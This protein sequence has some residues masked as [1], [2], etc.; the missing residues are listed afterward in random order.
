MVLDGLV[1]ADRNAWQQ[2]A[3]L[4]VW[5]TYAVT[6][7]LVPGRPRESRLEIDL[8]LW[9]G[10]LQPTVIKEE[11][12]SPFAGEA[13]PDRVEAALNRLVHQVMVSAH[14]NMTQS[15]TASNRM[16]IGQSLVETYNQMT[17]PTGHHREELGFEDPGKFLQAAH[18][19]ETA[20][21]FDPDNANA[22][23]LYISYRWGFWINFKENVKNQFW[24]KW[25]CSQAWGKY[26]NRFGLK[27]V[28]VDLPFPYQ[29]RGGLPEAY[30]NSLEEALKMFPQWDSTNEMENKWQQEG[31]HTWLVEAELH[32]FPK[33][34]PRDLA[35]KWQ[36]ETEAELGRRKQKVAEYLQSISAITNNH[37]GTTTSVIHQATV[38]LAPRPVSKPQNYSQMVPT[39]S[40]V[41]GIQTFQAFDSMFR[42]FPPNVLPLEVQPNM[43]E[44]RFPKQFEVQTIDHLDFLD[45]KLLILAMDERSVPSSDNNPDV[46]AEMLDKHNRLW[47]LKP[48]EGSPTLYEPDLFPQS[49]N[50]FLLKDGQLWVAGKTTGFLDLKTHDFR[51]FGLPD[52][53]DLQTSDALGFAGGHIF[54]A[55]DWF[56]VSMFDAAQ[57]HWSNLSLPPANLS[58]GTGSPFLLAGNKQQLVCVAGS[59]LIHDFTH[60]SWTNLAYPNS[61][62][63]ILADDS[64]FWFGGRDGLHSYDPASKSFKHWSAPSTINSLFTSTMGHSFMGNDEIPARD[65]ERMDEQ[66]QGLMNKLQ[67]DRAKNH[68]AKHGKN[69]M[70]DPLHL[71]WRVPGEATALANDGDF[72]WV[73][74]GNYFGNYLLLLHKPSH[75]LVAFCPMMARDHISSLTVSSTSIWIGTAYGDHKLLQLP[76]SP[77]LSVPQGRWVSLTIS[78]EERAQLVRNMDVRDQAMYAFYADDDARVA[79]LL[80]GIDPDKASLEEMFILAFSYDASGLDKPELARD[81]FEHIISRYP[82]S[83]WAKFARSA[84]AQ[85]EQ[86]HKDKMHEEE[87]LAKYD[88]DHNGVL[89]PEE[90]RVMERDPGYQNERKIWNADRL[91]NQLEK[92]M[93]RFDRNKDGKLDRGELESLK[94]QVTVFSQAPPEKLVGHKNPVV[95]LMTKKFPAVTDILQKYDVNGDGGLEAGELKMLAQ[96][97]QKGQ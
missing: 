5:G 17:N 61:I 41:K 88:R 53:Y 73:G 78:P 77:F 30:V 85:N 63:Q 27:P 72:L 23:V 82:D 89:D 56:K 57:N 28:E 43:Q 10:S 47:V 76:K 29:Q 38:A 1:E 66:I 55:G 20:C 39:P 6:N 81:W 69:A 44:I 16:K 64:G 65:L 12:S 67:R 93:Q 87:L 18:M 21:F 34:M 94:A 83:P 4:Y 79:A 8:H 7:R 19:L 96:D 24:S 40:W 9:D 86:N 49:V 15:D 42:L 22:R 60:N 32:G 54:A 70:A 14:K 74:V 33:E 26:V 80:G 52:G 92:I 2:T 75:S 58:G 13:P 48:G 62:Q 3:D 35:M 71:D 11:I 31:V 97:I 90:K 46:S 91:E 95:P 25:R 50:T 37:E 59:V 68:T 45:D 51:K 84:L 36:T